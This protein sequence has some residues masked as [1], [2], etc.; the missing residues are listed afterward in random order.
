MPYHICYRSS[1]I[2]RDIAMLNESRFR[3]VIPL[4]PAVAFGGKRVVFLY[5]LNIGLVEIVEE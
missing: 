2:E 4:A 5:S 1:D 3:T